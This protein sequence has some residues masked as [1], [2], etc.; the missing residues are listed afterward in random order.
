MKAISLMIFSCTLLVTSFAL[1]SFLSIGI[2]AEIGIVSGVTIFKNW[3]TMKAY[4]NEIYDL[5]RKLKEVDEN[6]MKLY[7][8][9]NDI[10]KDHKQTDANIRLKLYKDA[11][12]DIKK[13]NES[14]N[15]LFHNI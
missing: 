6:N 8:I 14:M 1:I 10:E 15:K 13:V 11:L 7:K 9:I 2:A 5:E 12:K 3:E 4:M